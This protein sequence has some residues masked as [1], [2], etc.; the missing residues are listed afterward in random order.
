MMIVALLGGKRELLYRPLVNMLA[1]SGY[2]VAAVVQ[3]RKSGIAKEMRDL[4]EAGAGLVAAYSANRVVLSTT[5]VPDTLEEI[6]KMMSCLAPV[7]PDVLV[8]LGFQKL[9][10]EDKRVLKALAVWSAKEAES[11]LAEISPPV[12]GV[13]SERGDYTEGYPTPEDLAAAIVD[14]GMRRR[15]IQPRV[16]RP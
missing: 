15:L 6:R 16:V 2:R 10:R 8:L 4:A 13:Y 7:D 14:E 1:S 9:I 3:L 5:Y 11:L 12:V